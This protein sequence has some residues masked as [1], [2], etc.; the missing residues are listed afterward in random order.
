M[1]T[2]NVYLNFKGNCENAFD[3]YKLIFGGEYEF[4]GRYKDIPQNARQNFPYCTDEQIM[5]VTLPIS[6][7][8]MLMGSDLINSNKEISEPKSGFSLYVNTD[9]KK[10]AERIFDA[11]SDE[12]EII[13]P[14]ADQFWGSYYGLC[15]DKFGISWKISCST[16]E[17]K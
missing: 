8:T 7:E 14:I 16:D 11:L 17:H 15:I 9:N 6:K 13:V 3:F 5:H 1:S 2:L 4:I 10:E 12:G